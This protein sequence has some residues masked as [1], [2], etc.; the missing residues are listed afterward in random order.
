MLPVIVAS[1]FPHLCQLT[2]RFFV[3]GELCATKCMVYEFNRL[4]MLVA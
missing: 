2:L 1:F 3:C 4:Y